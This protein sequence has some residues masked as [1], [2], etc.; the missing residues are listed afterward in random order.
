MIRSTLVY[1]FVGAYV[2]VAAPIALL[3]TQ[4]TG[5]TTFVYSLSR[6]CIRLAGWICGIKIICHGKE[7][8]LPNQT[9]VFLSNHQG[10]F[11]GPIIVHVTQRDLRALIKQE[12][13]RLPLLSI[14]LKK[15]HFV[16]IDRR[17]PR[18]ARTGIDQGADLLKEGYSFF[19]FPEGTRSR[20]GRLGEFKKGVFIMALKAGTPVVPITIVDSNRIQPPGSYAI[21]PGMVE[22][23]FHDPI[24]TD[25][26]TFE[27][28]HKLVAMTRAAIA[29]ALPGNDERV[30]S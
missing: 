29:S 24:P 6:F 11:D 19:A 23:I 12:M 30:A 17:D 18:K 15:L 3:W 25:K 2:L 21:N 13:M 4:L 8:L 26:M 28:R 16:P 5:D 9:Y 1:L 22:V 14:V 7:K 10:N 27:D 20:N